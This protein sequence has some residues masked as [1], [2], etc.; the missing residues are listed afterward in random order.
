MRGTL[1]LVVLALLAVVGAVAIYATHFDDGADQPD[2]VPPAIY[3]L[4]GVGVISLLGAAVGMVKRRG[5]NE[6][7]RS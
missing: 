2:W 6:T 7:R 3:I 1:I 4:L 5:P